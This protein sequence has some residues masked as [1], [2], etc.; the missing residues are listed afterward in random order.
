MMV[1]K[2]DEDTTVFPCHFAPSLEDKIK[3]FPVHLIKCSLK[4]WFN[5]HIV[6]LLAKSSM[7][8]LAIN[9]ASR[10]CLP[11]TNADW[12]LVMV[13]GRVFLRRSERTMAMILYRQ[14]MRLMGL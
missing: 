7:I 10:I 2:F 13:E 5:H 6:F 14:E 12:N 4:V 3:E 8:S 1:E 11:S 9:D